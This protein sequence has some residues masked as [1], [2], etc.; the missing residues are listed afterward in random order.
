MVVLGTT[1]MLSACGSDS[2]DSKTGGGDPNPPIQQ[3][4]NVN[5]IQILDANNQPIANVAVKIVSA[6]SLGINYQEDSNLFSPTTYLPTTTQFGTVVLTTDA[7]GMLK[8]NN[9][10]P[11]QY[12]VLVNEVS[13]PAITS[14]VLKKQN[15]NA[16]VVLNVPLSC[17]TTSQC[18]K[19]D[20]IVGSLAGQ[21]IQNGKPVQNAQVAI[22]G[23][24]ATNGAFITG[25]TDQNGQFNLTFNVSNAFV[26]DLKNATLLINAD[27]FQSVQKVILVNSSASFGNQFVLVPVTATGN[28]VWRET[29]ETDS[30]TVNAWTTSSSL[31]QP[32][33]N[34]LKAGHGIK[35]N[36]VGTA[37]KLAPNDTTNGAVPNPPQGVQAYW[38]GDTQQ[39]NFIGERVS[40]EDKLDGGTSAIKNIGVL[41]SPSIDLSKATKPLS[42][43]FKTWWEIEAVNPN[44]NGFDLME[45]QVSTDG[46]KN[47]KTIARLNPLSDPMTTLEKAPLPFTN[48]GFNVAPAISQQ[49][50]ISMDAYVGQANVKLRFKLET[51]DNLYNGFRGWMVDDIQIKNQPGTFPLFDGSEESDQPVAASMMKM[52]NVS[53]SVPRWAKNPQR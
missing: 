21:V 48:L 17:P 31:K 46:G 5:S 12:F 50:P 8:V 19:V 25:L 52:M 30:P 20:A 26:N 23:G 51:V 34:L 14:F 29:F 49:E 2:S 36:L 4:Q 10:T 18:V 35:N 44:N 11:D 9:L 39:G 27:G 24:N 28:T 32:V 16:K 41:T 1:M 7:Q 22:S 43:N 13:S 53:Y 38:Y 45:I 3:Q 33:W 40:Y 47:Y 6:S 37:V 42:L 15:S